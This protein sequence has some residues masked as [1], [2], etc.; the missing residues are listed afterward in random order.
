MNLRI[1][2]TEDQSA[3]PAPTAFLKTVED[4]QE[5]RP[6]V[7]APAAN[8]DAQPEAHRPNLLVR[9]RKRRARM[10]ARR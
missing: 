5:I 10:A 6:V 4:F 1:Q 3:A 2:E 9:R 8:D 7:E